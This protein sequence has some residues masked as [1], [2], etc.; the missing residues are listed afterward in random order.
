[1][2]NLGEGVY[3][4]CTPMKDTKKYLV[5][6]CRQKTHSSHAALPAKCAY[7]CVCGLGVG[8]GEV[9]LCVGVLQEL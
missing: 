7:D 8:W 3:V 9:S 5:L 1:M 4:S 2:E 6:A